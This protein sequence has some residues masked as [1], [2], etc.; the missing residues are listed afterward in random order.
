MSIDNCGLEL[1]DPHSPL[2]CADAI[3]RVLLNRET[4]LASQQQ[5]R[6]IFLSYTW[7]DA[8]TKYYQLFFKPE[9]V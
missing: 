4:V 2:E 3:E 8:A 7:K 5:F 9:L 6:E 1:F